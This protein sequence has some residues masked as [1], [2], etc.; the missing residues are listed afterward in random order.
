MAITLPSIPAAAPHIWTA[1]NHRAF[2]LVFYAKIPYFY[3]KMPV[4]RSFFARFV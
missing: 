4:F 2:F 1:Q 3:P